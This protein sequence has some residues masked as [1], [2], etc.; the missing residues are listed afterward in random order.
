MSLHANIRDALIASDDYTYSDWNSPSVGKLHIRPTVILEYTGKTVA[1]QRRNQRHCYN[2]Y[3]IYS[4][5]NKKEPFTDI[6]AL[7]DN[8]IEFINANVDNAYPE[9]MPIGYSSNFSPVEGS[10][11][12]YR[13]FSVKILSE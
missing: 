1:G 4:V 9:I 6:E 5:T 7:V 3:V 2:A 12:S 11:N 8:F 10:K 13:A